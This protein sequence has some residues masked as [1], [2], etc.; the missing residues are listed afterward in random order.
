MVLI[1]ASIAAR[2]CRPLYVALG[3]QCVRLNA[4][5]LCK[6]A[7]ELFACRLHPHRQRGQQGD[8]R[9]SKI[10]PHPDK[11][12]LR[13]ATALATRA[14]R[15]PPRLSKVMSPSQTSVYHGAVASATRP[16]RCSLN[17]LQPTT[18]LQ[19]SISRGGTASAT[20]AERRFLKVLSSTKL[21]QASIF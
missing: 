20:R 15:Q 5:E 21:S 19:A 18:V 4:H 8:G 10:Q 6:S 11:H 9:E 3:Q 13:G 1:P 16:A 2:S 14:A 17:V 12:Q 7:I